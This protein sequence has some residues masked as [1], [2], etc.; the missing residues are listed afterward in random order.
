[1]LLLLLLLL[2]LSSPPGA[3]ANDD[4]GLSAQV[5]ERAIGVSMKKGGGEGSIG[6]AFLSRLILG[7]PSVSRR[8]SYERTAPCHS[9]QKHGQ[10]A[11][12]RILYRGQGLHAVQAPNAV[13]SGGHIC[14]LEI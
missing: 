11:G 7:S 4:D 8:P 10:H 13:S 6:F 9:E 14:L 2:L 12:R 1:M 5:A 3:V